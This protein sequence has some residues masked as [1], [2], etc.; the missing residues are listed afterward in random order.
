[1]K[2]PS[3]LYIDD[4]A[5]PLLQAVISYQDITSANGNALGTT[6]VCA[7]LATEP[8]YQGLAVKVL[9][10]DAAGQVKPISIH[11]AGANT[12]TV[13]S[14]FTDNAGAVVQIVAS[15][16]FVIL[17]A[18]G[19]GAPAPVLSPS[20]GLWMFGEC[21][22]GMAASTTVLTIPNLAGFPDDIFNDE[23]WIQ[24]IHNFDVPSTAPEREIKQVTNYVGATGVFTTDAFSA[25][26]EA[27]DLVCVFHESV[28]SMEILG[29]GTLTV[30]SLTVPADGGRAAL[31]AWENNGYFRGCLLQPTEGNCR[32]QPRPI[33]NYTSATGVF[34]LAEPFSQLPGGVDYVII[35]SAFPAGIQ[36][37]I[38]LI[39]DLVNA[40]LVTTETGGSVLTDGNEQDI[41][42]NDAPAGNF[43]PLVVFIDFSNQTA[44]E[45]VVIRTYYRI[46]PGGALLLNDELTYVGIQDPVLI[47]ID[48]KPNR[49]GLRVSIQRTAGGAF[50]YPWEVLY[51]A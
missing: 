12:L 5:W 10:G 2:T 43:E 14:P 24:V 13:A 44:A 7:G 29:F 32:F 23:F 35:G 11:V 49:Y 22:A 36:E 34:T 42:I 15:T 46:A 21:D 6:I 31:Y 30:N 47:N 4:P 18:G 28:M 33:L 37:N 20:I 1:M 17:S 41:Y 8:S 27:N 45:T 9:D 48:L 16:R 38:D 26:V 19:G 51:R 50:A 40:M 3:G 39:F 25:N